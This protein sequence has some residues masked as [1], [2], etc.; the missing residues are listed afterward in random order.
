MKVVADTGPLV[1]AADRSDRAH[2]LAAHLL[3]ELVPYV[4]VPDAVVVEA[5]YLMRARASE[6]AARRFLEDLREGQL[7]RVAWSHVLFERAVAYERAYRDLGLGIVDG[8]VMALAEAEHASVLTFD[9]TD[10]R[11]T[12]PLR[13]GFWRLV[14]DEDQYRRLMR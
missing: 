7:S 6:T 5:Y 4:L 10:F 14:V 2:A 12:R 1:S 13:G 8:S 9:Y 3:A 11:A